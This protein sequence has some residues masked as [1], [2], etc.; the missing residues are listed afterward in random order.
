MRE[1]GINRAVSSLSEVKVFPGSPPV[2]GIAYFNIHGISSSGKEERNFDLKF[3][4]DIFF[5]SFGFD[6]QRIIVL[7]GPIRSLF[8]IAV[9][10]D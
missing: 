6:S 2:G 9:Q 7:E 3:P 1:I 5:K 4:I 10:L 8:G